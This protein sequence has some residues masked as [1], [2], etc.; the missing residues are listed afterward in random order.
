MI[1]FTVTEKSRRSNPL[2]VNRFVGAFP[3]CRAISFVVK[4]SSDTKN[5]ISRVRRYDWEVSR[6]IRWVT[7]ECV[8]QALPINAK[9]MR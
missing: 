9:L 3:R 8:I 4:G 7:E 5:S 6:F 2:I 1:A